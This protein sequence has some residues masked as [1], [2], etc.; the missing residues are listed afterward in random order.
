M[1]RSIETN[2]NEK[3]PDIGSCRVSKM[4]D[5]TKMCMMN[6]HCSYELPF[7]NVCSHPM[8]GMIATPE[9]R[10]RD[11]PQIAQLSISRSCCK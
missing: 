1:D 5:G 9:C 6:T 8:V 7:S 11:S 3:Q 4:S 10:K 2:P